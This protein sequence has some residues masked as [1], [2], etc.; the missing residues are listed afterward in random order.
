MNLNAIDSK[1]LNKQNSK[2]N[3]ITFEL[4][5]KLDDLSEKLRNAQGENAQS[6]KKE[7]IIVKQEIAS[8]NLELVTKFAKYYRTESF[9]LEDIIQEGYIALLHAID[10]YDYKKGFSF[11]NYAALAIKNSI[12]R[13][14][15]NKDRMI[16]V[17]E[18]INRMQKKIISYK[19]QYKNIYNHYPSLENIAEHFNIS[20]KKVQYLNSIFIKMV[21]LDNLN[22][23]RGNYLDLID[24]TDI[25]ENYLLKEKK[26]IISECLS[27]LSSNEEEII[28]LYYNIPKKDEKNPIYYEH[29]T[30]ES[31]SKRI[32]FSKEQIRKLKLNGLA[33]LSKMEEI[34]NFDREDNLLLL[35]KPLKELLNISRNEMLS[36]INQLSLKK[37]N[38]IIKRFGLNLNEQHIDDF[39]NCLKAY[40]IIE[41][42]KQN[43]CAKSKNYYLWEILNTDYASLLN[44]L[45]VISKNDKNYA[46]LFY[47]FG[48]NLDLP[49]NVLSIELT[50]QNAFFEAIEN[51]GRLFVPRCR[52]DKKIVRILEKN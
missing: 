48:D 17:P 37:Q 22:K 43:N 27:R 46:I 41:E 6:L 44:V 38:I 49:L 9:E 35:Y 16:R 39:S 11:S 40:Q 14:I 4:F 23:E 24:T 47:Y 18:Y 1:D 25:E 21:S 42:M 30:L 19:E 20:L 29:N 34:K 10:Y 33:K 28:R 50:C 12:L 32:G 15:D 5:K 3:D 51:I 36:L 8:R 2:D 31:I 13:A 45:P 7:Y 52:P 26:E